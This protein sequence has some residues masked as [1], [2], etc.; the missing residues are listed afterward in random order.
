[1]LTPEAVGIPGA[2]AINDLAIDRLALA[3][4]AGRL[5]SG[6]IAF[7]AI[8]DATLA[9]L[10][11]LPWPRG[12]FGR[13]LTRLRA[14]GAR[15]AAL[16]LEF[17]TRRDPLEDAKM[18]AGMRALPTVI[19][20]T[21]EVSGDGRV[22]W[23]RA[24]PVIDA[25]VSAYGFTSAR[26]TGGYLL[27][28]AVAVET[29]NGKQLFSLPVA[30]ARSLLDAREIDLNYGAQRLE[31]FEARLNEHGA[32]A[33]AFAPSE[34][35]YRVLAMPR[36]DLERLVRDRLVMVGILSRTY[37]YFQTTS[38]EY[39]GVLIDLRLADQLLRFKSLSALPAALDTALVISFAVFALLTALRLRAVASITVTLA[40]CTA[41][42]VVCLWSFLHSGFYADIIHVNAGAFVVSFLS[43]GIMERHR[44]IVARQAREELAARELDL[45]EERAR[46]STLT[47]Y[48]AAMQRFLPREF[49]EHIG[50]SSIIDVE[51]GD[52]VERS[53]VV[54]FSDIRDF[55]TRSEAMSPNETFR[56][57]NEYLGVAGPI[58][59]S[60]QGFIDKYI[61]DAIMALFPGTPDDA[62]R[63]AIEL[64]TRARAHAGA[65]FA[66]GVGLHF[67]SLILG[68]IGEPERMDTTVIADAV[69]IAAR[70]EGLT[71]I[72]TAPI[73]ASGE[74]VDALVAR[75]TFPLRRLGSV[76]VTGKATP[77]TLYEILDGDDS[78]LRDRKHATAERFAGALE[79]FEAGRF[80]AAARAFAD[81]RA[82]APGDGPAAYLHARSIAL[83]KETPSRWDGVDSIGTK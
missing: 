60:H 50:R 70:I 61:C 71:K 5:G 75:E 77:T 23:V 73:L 4:G 36:S 39:P 31:P 45:I 82:A 6:K 83:E 13:F 19:G 32:L 15:V 72:Y 64:Q 79:A 27:D 18:A 44:S 3:A 57:L 12:T 59:R 48:N 69:N 7:I 33:P 52:H 24:A 37:P 26:L 74:L 63:A 65:G 41:E 20:T 46:S 43:S 40:A 56:F 42:C 2:R 8:D 16:D 81:L 58:I 78:E 10:G 55:T 80:A 30:A 17:A 67:G 47:T 38:G 14:A 49:L 22:S 34:S 11:P 68:T 1:M 66:A 25:A 21:L 53:M 28:N 54:L 29:A 62:L 9:V 76:R 51:L 35:F